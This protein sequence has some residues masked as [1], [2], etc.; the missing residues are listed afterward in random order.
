MM[1]IKRYIIITLFFLFQIDIGKAQ[2]ETLNVGDKIPDHLFK[3]INTSEAEPRATIISFWATWCVPC[4][5][6]MKLLDSIKKRVD[7]INIISITYEDEVTVDNFFSNRTDLKKNDLNIIS[8]DTLFNRYFPHRILPHNIWISPDG[9]VDYITGSEEVRIE[10]IY[11][12]LEGHPIEND[13]KEDVVHFDPFEPFHLRDSNFTYRSILTEHIKGIYGGVSVQ[14]VGNEANR[15]II[16]LFSFNQSLSSLLWRAINHGKSYKDYY[17]LMDIETTD[18]TR[19]FWPS[20]APL[21]FDKSKYRTKGEWMEDNTFCYE[22]SLAEAVADSVFY[23][24]MLDDLKRNFNVRV[25]IVEDS[26]WCSVLTLDNKIE[27][28]VQNR[29]SSCIVLDS[30]GLVAKNVSVLYLMEY[31]NEKVKVKIND[32]PIDPPF[33]DRT[34]GK[35]IDIEIEFKCGIPNYMELKKT[36]QKKYGITIRK[37]RDR[38]K[39]VVI[40]DLEV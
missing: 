13:R 38:F 20:A 30:S 37:E 32:V 31:L 39:R 26:I 25:D 34:K 2:I 18:S 11:A 28:N 19:F 35:K 8:S 6:E 17:N 21:S 14:N 29:D 4:I 23:R 16:R 40:R 1:A 3:T 24:Y 22:L 10:N 5:R 27:L 12:F 9:I 33:I 15:Q 36:L 7:E